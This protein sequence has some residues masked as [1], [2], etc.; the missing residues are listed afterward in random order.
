MQG[1]DR[2]TGQFGECMDAIAAVVP[3]GVD[4]EA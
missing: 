1:L 4:C 3:H 2:D